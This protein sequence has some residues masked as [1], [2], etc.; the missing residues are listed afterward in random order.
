MLRWPPGSGTQS[1][2]EVH[3]AASVTCYAITRTSHR[4][5]CT[6]GT[7][8]RELAPWIGCWTRGWSIRRSVPP[9]QPSLGWRSGIGYLEPIFSECCVPHQL[10]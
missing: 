10:G 5:G 6:S 1:K 7:N 8:G 4:P 9:A 2:V 3:S